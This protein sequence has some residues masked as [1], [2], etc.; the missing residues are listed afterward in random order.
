MKFNAPNQVARQAGLTLVE[1]C[2]QQFSAIVLRQHLAGMTNAA[3]RLA[4]P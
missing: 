4:M 1:G 3:V 2:V